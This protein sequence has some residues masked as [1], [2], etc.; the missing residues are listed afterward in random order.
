MVL[1]RLLLVFGLLLVCVHADYELSALFL[2]YENP[3]HRCGDP[4]ECSTIRCCDAS[5]RDSPPSNPCTDSRCDN[6]FE[7]CLRPLD[8]GDERFPVSCTDGTTVR[9]QNFPRNDDNIAFDHGPGGLDNGE[10]NPYT[11]IQEG[12]WMVSFSISI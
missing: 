4:E 1:S 8:T 9:T 7:F 12:S 3:S 2:S 10:P 5:A 11:F 6:F